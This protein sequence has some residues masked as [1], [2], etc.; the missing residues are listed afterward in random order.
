MTPTVDAPPAPNT[1]RERIISE[2]LPLVRQVVRRLSLQN[3]GAACDIDDLVGFGIVG[4]VQAVDRF[5]PSG[6]APFAAFAT[7]R[8][9]GA[10]LDAV[11]QLDPLSRDQRS[12]VARIRDARDHL[13]NSLSREPTGSEVRDA[14]QLSSIAFNEASVAAETTT[15]LSADDEFVVCVS[16]EESCVEFVERKE[17]DETLEDAVLSLPCSERAAVQMYFFKDLNQREIS[18]ALSLSETRVSQLISQALRTLRSKLAP[19]DFPLRPA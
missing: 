9:K 14:A 1:D 15:V 13:R 8:I 11:R 18:Q 17:F 7:M 6:G 12:R 4:L 2:H 19:L 3:F 16:N 5:D 10:V